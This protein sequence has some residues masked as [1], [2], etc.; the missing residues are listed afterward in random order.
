M[1]YQKATVK[2]NSHLKLWFILLSK[3]IKYL[4]IKLSREMNFFFFLGPHLWHLEIPR[5]GV[6][7]SHRNVGSKLHLPPTPLAHGI[8]WSLMQWV[9]TEVESHG[10]YS[11]SLPLSHNRKNT[12]KIYILKTIKH[13]WRKRKIIQKKM[14]IYSMLLD[15][16]I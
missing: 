1:K 8:T 15:W 9:G 16:K 6:H 3:R 14:E 10:C 13:W 12:C 5:I 2:N 4:W 7:H 11:G